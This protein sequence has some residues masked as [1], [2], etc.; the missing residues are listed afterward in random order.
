MY[1]QYKSNVWTHCYIL[2]FFKY[3]S[4]AHQKL[5]LFDQKKVIFSKDVLKG[6]SKDV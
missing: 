4:Y 6:D 2:M 3:I 1:I 5:N